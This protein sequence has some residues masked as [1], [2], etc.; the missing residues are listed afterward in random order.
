MWIC[1]SAWSCA[2]QIDKCCLVPS[3]RV[4]DAVRFIPLEGELAHRGF[5]RSRTRSRPIRAETLGIWDVCMCASVELRAPCHEFRLQYFPR[6]L[7]PNLSSS[8]AFSLGFL[9]LKGGEEK[10]TGLATSGT[11]TGA[12]R[13]SRHEFLSRPG[14]GIWQVIFRGR[15]RRAETACSRQSIFFFDE[16]DRN[17]S[18]PPYPFP[19]SGHL[20]ATEHR[21]AYNFLFGRT[22]SVL[23]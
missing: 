10:S 6:L 3:S 2:F 9:V 15:R 23:K 22:H 21:S 20:I 18:L 19:A 13:Y 14:Y 1:P 17:N 16:T 11:G 8:G 4:Y 12:A 5:L 7:C